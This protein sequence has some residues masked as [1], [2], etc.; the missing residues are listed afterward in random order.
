M[1]TLDFVLN[2]QAMDISFMEL[3]VPFRFSGPLR[4]SNVEFDPGR[5][6]PE[7]VKTARTIASFNNPLV[8]LGVLAGQALLKDQNGC[9]T[10]NMI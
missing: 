1:G 7:A 2:P 3:A 6:P 8:G 4:T 5:A 9:E 10:A